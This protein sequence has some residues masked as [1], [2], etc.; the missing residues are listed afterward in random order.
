MD[1]EQ[2][3]DKT[4]N[5]IIILHNLDTSYVKVKT[6]SGKRTRSRS[7]TISQDENDLINEQ[8]AVWREGNFECRCQKLYK[9]PEYARCL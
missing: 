4:L 5:I 7:V 9:R 1:F 8:F 2:G 3:D 6:M